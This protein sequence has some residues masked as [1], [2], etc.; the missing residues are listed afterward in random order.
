MC[1]LI[2]FHAVWEDA[3]LV[4]AVNR[5][6]AYDRPA[7]PPAVVG[8]RPPVLMPRD[9]RAGGTWMGANAGGLWVG[10]TNRD[11]GEK[12]PTRR[13]RGLLCLDLLEE[14]GPEAVVARIQTLDR[15]YNP[16][17]LVAGDAT[18]LWLVEHA[19]GRSIPRRLGPGVHLVT[20][21]PFVETP[22]ESKA[23]RARWRLEDEGLWP[24]RPGGLA[25]DGLE[26]RLAAI[27][28]DHG[29]RGHD[30]LCLHGGRYGTRSGAVWR[31]GMPR[32]SGEAATLLAY[33]DGPPCSTRFERFRLP[34]IS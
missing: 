24:E 9:E 20:N 11:G 14:T 5:D 25:P 30:A 34:S 2:A 19:E 17:N 7:S 8:S 28:G 13:S 6:E 10:L 21:R 15:T 18:S 1:T 16:F 26:V 22:E 3:P 31:I 29:V 33:A 27:L 4:L 23:G 12:N 32:G